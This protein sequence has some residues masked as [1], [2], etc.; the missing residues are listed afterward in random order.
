MV[1]LMRFD[2][3]EGRWAEHGVVCGE[4]RWVEHGVVEEQDRLRSDRP[5]LVL[6]LLGG[7][8]GEVAVTCRYNCGSYTWHRLGVVSVRWQCR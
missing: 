3:G 8:I 1:L 7:S 6:C 5:D 4:G 2:R